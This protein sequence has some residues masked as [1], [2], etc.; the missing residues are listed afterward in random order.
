MVGGKVLPLIRNSGQKGENVTGFEIGEPADDRHQSRRLLHL[1]NENGG[2]CQG[3]A[4]EEL[5]VLSAD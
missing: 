2:T 3:A 5:R 1:I 4:I